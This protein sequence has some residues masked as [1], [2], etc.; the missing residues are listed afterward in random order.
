MS[1]STSV[2]PTHS[3]GTF[4]KSKAFTITAHIAR[5]LLGLIFLVFGLNGFLHFITMPP[6]TGTAAE[7]F[8]GLVKAQYFLPFMAFVQVVC[9]ILLLSGSLIPF[10][11]LLLFPISINIFFFHLAIAP[12]G[13]GLAVLIMAANILLAVY[14]WPVYK[15]I[16][17]I[18]NA[19]RSKEHKQSHKKFSQS[20]MIF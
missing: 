10:A 11:L 12:T 17:K 1:Q 4:S 14:Y 15:P 9:G 8:Y 3:T 18:E 6:P 7:F 19:W 13:L 16:F 20:Y 2:V 5:V